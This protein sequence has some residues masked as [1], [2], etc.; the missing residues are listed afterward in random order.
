MNK[1][2]RS[3]DRKVTNLV[4][5]KGNGSLIKNTFGLPA[6]KNYSCPGATSVCEKVC[7]AGKLEKLYK[8]VKANLLHNWELLKNADEPTMV[9]LLEDMINDFR[10]ECEKRGAEKLFRIH[11]DGDFFSDTYA[12]AWQYIIINNQDI[13]FW[14]YTRVESAVYI[15]KNLDNLS[16]YYSTDS[17]NIDTAKKLSIDEG[18]KLAYLAD[19][20]AMGKEQLLNLVNAKGVPCPEN[21]K[22]IPLIDKGGSACVKCGQCVFNRNNILFSAS[23]K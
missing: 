6:G 14:V 16:L 10:D 20:F 3:H 8:A 15:L 12:R 19:T 11:W 23:K 21:N 2:K 17:E 5:N 18:I 4:N 9:H 13:K 1:L 22:K 7:Y